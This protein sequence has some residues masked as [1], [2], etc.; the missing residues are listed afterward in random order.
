MLERYGRMDG[1][2]VF[3]ERG[4]DINQDVSLEY[5][6]LYKQNQFHWKIIVGE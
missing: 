4:S 3:V 6:L 2:T 1:E 5:A